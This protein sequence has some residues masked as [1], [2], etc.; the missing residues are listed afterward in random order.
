MP[1]ELPTIAACPDCRMILIRT[2]RALVHPMSGERERIV[3]ALGLYWFE[4]SR[5]RFDGRFHCCDGRHRRTRPAAP[6][7]EAGRPSNAA[8]PDMEPPDEPAGRA[9]IRFWCLLG[10]LAV[11]LSRPVAAQDLAGPSALSPSLAKLEQAPAGEPKNLEHDTYATD[12]ADAASDPARDRAGVEPGDEATSWKGGELADGRYQI[13]D[14]LRDDPTG[15]V[16]LAHDRNLDTHVIVEVPNLAKGA[17]S[18]RSARFVQAI[19]ALAR[20]AHPHLVRVTEV[21]TRGGRPYVISEHLSGGS[22]KFRRPVGPS[23]RPEPMP[24]ETLPEWLPAVAGALDYLHSQER[25]HADLKPA[26]ILFD[27]QGRAYL[28]GLGMAEATAVASH[29]SRA[30]QRSLA[31]TVYA[32]LSGQPCQE[33]QD[34]S[35]TPAQPHRP[36]HL[37]VPSVSEPLSQV[38]ERG[39]SPDPAERFPDCAAFARAALSAAQ[40]GSE[41]RRGEK[42]A[43]AG[44]A[45]QP[46]KVRRGGSGNAEGPREPSYARS[47]VAAGLL[48][49]TLIAAVGAGSRRRSARSKPTTIRRPR[50]RALTGP[51]AEAAT[52]PER[53]AHE[54]SEAIP[55]GP[56][57]EAPGSPVNTLVAAPVLRRS[58]R[59]R[60]G[61]LTVMVHAHPPHGVRSGDE[62]GDSAGTVLDNAL[63]GPASLRRL[64]APARATAVNVPALLRRRRAS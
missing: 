11:L 32:L 63:A 34:A 28:G 25:T 45:T 60:R 36:L 44:G 5:T 3:R 10:T 2:S 6:N 33:P 51:Q 18:T 38:V 15:S 62:S 7:K 52:P 37:V 20:L 48:G 4:H 35:A 8:H 55:L 47:L 49:S 54:P 24:V 40:R 61:W 41:P 29:D 26:N 27:A 23:G 21:G 14:T 12:L 59:V 1:A 64:S 57:G 9:W 58:R 56:A 19:R 42:A 46:L 31:R 53:P 30:D 43:L 13:V 22:L 39:L 50:P 17:S 16:Y